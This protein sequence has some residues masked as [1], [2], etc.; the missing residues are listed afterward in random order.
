[1]R[2]S[3]TS[4]R[5]KSVQRVT[6]WSADAAYRVAAR[7]A[8]IGQ[9]QNAALKFEVCKQV[10]KTKVFVAVLAREYLRSNAAC[11]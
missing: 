6:T 11:K 3:V 8:H 5:E 2:Y 9:P 1:M 7:A 4:V 10:R